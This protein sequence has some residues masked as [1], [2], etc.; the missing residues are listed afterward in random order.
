LSCCPLCWFI[1]WWCSRE[2]RLRCNLD[3]DT[4]Q[5]FVQSS[6]LSLSLLLLF[7]FLKWRACV[8]LKW[9][10]LELCRCL[11]I[12]LEELWKMSKISSTFV[13]VWVWIWTQDLLYVN[14]C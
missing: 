10:N 1:W 11:Y 3:L 12:C 2:A 14:E 4:T 8:G 9:H 5:L 6:L 13:G 7:L